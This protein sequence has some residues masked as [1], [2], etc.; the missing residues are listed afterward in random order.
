MFEKGSIWY[1]A[2]TQPGTL[3]KCWFKNNVDMVVYKDVLPLH[4]S[5]GHRAASSEVKDHRA[6][7]Q[8]VHTSPWDS[9]LKSISL[10]LPQTMCQTEPN[11]LPGAFPSANNWSSQ[12]DV[13]PASGHDGVTWATKDT[14]FGAKRASECV[15]LFGGHGVRTFA[16][17]VMVPEVSKYPGKLVQYRLPI[18]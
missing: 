11:A 3:N 14:P 5:P 8:H 12:S 4:P 6:W 9:Q 10:I 15:F 13:L 17:S 18:F 7:R 1:L 16:R 2:S